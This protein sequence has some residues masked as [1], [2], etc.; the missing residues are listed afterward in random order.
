MED[1]RQISGCKT[2]VKLHGHKLHLR[3]IFFIF[4]RI[5]ERRS[6]PRCSFLNYKSPS[7]NSPQPDTQQR[8][9]HSGKEVMVRWEVKLT[10]TSDVAVCLFRV[11][12]V[13]MPYESESQTVVNEQCASRLSGGE[14][15]ALTSYSSPFPLAVYQQPFERKS[16]DG[17]DELRQNTQCHT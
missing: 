15:P 16:T 12:L 5:L 6:R 9:R 10:W 8:A 17:S 7:A 11:F 13:R 2:I 1:G 14:L 4:F 3:R